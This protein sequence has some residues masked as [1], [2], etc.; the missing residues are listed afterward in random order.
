MH[1]ILNH[2]DSITIYFV[3]AELLQNVIN[4]TRKIQLNGTSIVNYHDVIDSR[5]K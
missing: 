4:N 3:T 2:Y 1:G 5:T